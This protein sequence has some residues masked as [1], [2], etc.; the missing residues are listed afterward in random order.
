MK[1]PMTKEL[2]AL[3][4]ASLAGSRIGYTTTIGNAGGTTFTD[5]ALIGAGANSF[6]SMSVVIA[7]D[8]ILTIDRAEIAAFNSATGEI[9]LETAYKGGQIAVGTQYALITT[10]AD[11]GPLTVLINAIKA[12]TDTIVT[13]SY[14]EQLIPIKM[15]C[16]QTI[17]ATNADKDFIPTDE[18]GASGLISTDDAKVQKAFLLIIG[19]A[20]NIYAGTNALDCTTATWNQWQMNLDGGAYS[21]L[22][23]E[24]ADGQLADDD[25]RC[26]VEGAIHP[27][28]FLCDITSQLTNI[29]GKIGVRL[30]TAQAEQISLITTIDVF[31]KILWKL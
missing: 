19:R 25:W 13:E 16:T 6:I 24:E 11:L 7:P 4:A 12:K 20:V 18:T 10:G 1:Y 23:N 26:A 17:N 8:S 5:A 21:D 2:I 30:A 14:F 27:F 22:V 15:N 31:L 28:V 9:T 29:D 3:I